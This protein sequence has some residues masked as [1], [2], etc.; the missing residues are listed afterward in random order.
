MVEDKF[1]SGMRGTGIGLFYGGANL[2]E[3]LVRW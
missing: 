3:D 2:V 1:V